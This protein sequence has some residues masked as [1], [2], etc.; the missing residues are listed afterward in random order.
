MPSRPAR[1]K[2]EQSASHRA[3]VRHPDVWTELHEQ[4]NEPSVVSQNAD[5]PRLDLV[6][7]FGMEV[8]HGVRHELRLAN[9]LTADNPEVLGAASGIPVCSPPNV[10]GMSGERALTG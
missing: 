6:C 4:L 2:L 3:R 8:L 7:D 10:F 9:P 1:T 5:R